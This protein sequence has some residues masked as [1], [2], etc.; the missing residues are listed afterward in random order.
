[1]AL[2]AKKCQSHVSELKVKM[3]TIFDG[4]KLPNSCEQKMVGVIIDNKLI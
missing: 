1:M 2:N 3:M 4:I